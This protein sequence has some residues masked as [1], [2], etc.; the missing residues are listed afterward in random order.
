MK[1]RVSLKYFVNDCSRASHKDLQSVQ[2]STALP[3][4]RLLSP[5][6]CKAVDKAPNSSANKHVKTL[7]H[8]LMVLMAAGLLAGP[9]VITTAKA[10]FLNLM[11]LS[12]L[13]I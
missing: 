7:P 11:L 4:L 8:S 1:T 2:T 12:R 10:P 13:Y 3:M 6:S 5:I 9:W